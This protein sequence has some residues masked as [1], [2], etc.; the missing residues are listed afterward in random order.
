MTITTT[1][2]VYLNPLFFRSWTF[3]TTLYWYFRYFVL[4]SIAILD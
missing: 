3:N 2:Y 1:V 4:L